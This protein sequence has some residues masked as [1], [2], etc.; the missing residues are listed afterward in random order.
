VSIGVLSRIPQLFFPLGDP[1]DFRKTQTAF[2]S[3][4]F[5]R[6]G[7]DL[8]SYP[9]PVLGNAQ[10]VPME[11]PIFQA[12]AA[13]LQHTGLTTEAAGQIV[14]LTM[15]QLSGLLMLLLA[16]EFFDP[17][18]ALV[19]FA[20]L[21]FAPYSM[22]WGSAFLIESTALAFTLASILCIHKIQRGRI[23]ALIFAGAGFAVLAFL[24]KSTT[25][26]GWFAGYGVLQILLTRGTGSE[27]LRRLMR[28]IT[29]VA[30]VGGIGLIAGLAW[31]QYADGVKSGHP[32]TALLTS[33]AL[34]AFNFGTLQQR[35]EPFTYVVFGA[36]T[37]LE[38]MGFTL[39]LL[40]LMGL[41]KL[42][43]REFGDF[44]YLAGMVC[45]AT[46]GPL[47]F[48]NIYTHDYYFIPLLPAMAI[49]AGW[50][51][52]ETARHLTLEGQTRVALVIMVMLFGTL[53]TSFW[54]AKDIAT[55]YT[56]PAFDSRALELVRHTSPQDRLVVVGCDW[57]PTMLYHADRQGLMI[58]DY[59][60]EEDVWRTGLGK[61]V[62]PDKVTRFEILWE[63]ESLDEYE[64]LVVCAERQVLWPTG[65]TFEPISGDFVFRII[66]DENL[67][68][69]LLP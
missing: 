63:K 7:I 43:K 57:N 5:F 18:V 52:V 37:W 61:D 23:T 69:G 41:I 12:L 16:R 2:V 58:P 59:Y 3:R 1:I 64:Y 35:L 65:F 30:I 40:P 67:D 54:G 38:I 66:S 32:L 28:R 19:A 13:T 55:A 22:E 17:Q 15:F 24:A 21:Q 11:M 36:R 14:S 6:N 29:P 62:F 68:S 50:S 26:V 56:P 33:E 9:L 20:I 25:P 34:S 4:E 42:R 27:E 10:S 47:V 44:P 48:F 53:W 46:F 31:T 51:I 45:A 49:L 39:L 60:I 8:L